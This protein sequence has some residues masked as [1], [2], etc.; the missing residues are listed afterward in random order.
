MADKVHLTEAQMIEIL[1][2]LENR[3]LERQALEEE[4]KIFV[5]PHLASG[6]KPT[7]TTGRP[8]SQYVGQ[9]HLSVLEEDEAWFKKTAQA[10]NIQYGKFFTY[11]RKVFEQHG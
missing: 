8:R 9:L 4:H 5:K 10:N 7:R 1:N 2:R 11:L 6:E 3:L